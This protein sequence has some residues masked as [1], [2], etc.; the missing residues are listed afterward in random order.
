MQQLKPGQ[1]APEFSLFD[2]D[3]EQVSL[4]DFRNRT[5][6]ILYF[7]PK[8]N[9]PQ[10]ALQATDFSDHEDE[11]AKNDCVIIGVSRDDC[12]CHAEFR[13]RHGISIRLLSDEDAVVCK[14]YGVWQIKEVD[15]LKRHGIVRS[16]FF[17]DRDGFI[18]L[19]LY[20]ITAKGHAAEM[21]RAAEEFKGN[22]HASR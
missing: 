8:D 9:T 11:F 12:L 21:L 7:Y 13:D 18:Q 14:L 6:V 1:Q 20:G 3:M 22:N 16:T 19:A 10:C 15:G 5:N 17:I 4:S 2:A